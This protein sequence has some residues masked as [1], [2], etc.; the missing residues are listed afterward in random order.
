MYTFVY[1]Q[2]FKGKLKSYNI[3]GRPVM[4][5]RDYLVRLISIIV[6]SILHVEK[7]IF[8]YSYFNELLNPN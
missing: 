4:L 3:Y 8:N 7:I 5:Y 1:N 2:F 6:I